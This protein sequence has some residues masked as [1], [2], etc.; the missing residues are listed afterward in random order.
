MSS[1]QREQPAS[2]VVFGLENTSRPSHTNK[3]HLKTKVVSSAGFVVV[4]PV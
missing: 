3:S 1:P 2:Q 4:R